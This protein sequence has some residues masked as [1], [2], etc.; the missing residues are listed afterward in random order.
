MTDFYPQRYR[1]VRDRDTSSLYRML[2]IA[3]EHAPA[4]LKAVDWNAPV[5]STFAYR[6]R[7]GSPLRGSLNFSHPLSAVIRTGNLELLKE[8]LAIA[9]EVYK[10]P[11]YLENERN[12]TSPH[13]WV[14]CHVLNTAVSLGEVSQLKVLLEAMAQNKGHGHRYISYTMEPNPWAAMASHGLADRTPAHWVQVLKLLDEQ[15]FASLRGVPLGEDTTVEIKP[16]RKLD[17]TERH[18]RQITHTHALECAAMGGNPAL[19]EAILS[20]K[21]ASITPRALMEA[22]R[23]GG[24]D[25]AVMMLQ[26]ASLETMGLNHRGE[27]TLED[28]GHQLT[29]AWHQWQ[30]ATV[31][32]HPLAGFT[33]ADI[34]LQKEAMLH[35]LVLWLEKLV[36]LRTRKAQQKKE[37]L[38][39]QAIESLAPTLAPVL[40]ALPTEQAETAWVH[41]QA[42]G[43]PL[44]TWKE[45]VE[46]G[47]P[48]YANSAWVRLQRERV[49]ALDE[50]SANAYV[51]QMG[52]QAQTWWT[53]VEQLNELYPLYQALFEDAVGTTLSSKAWLGQASDQL[54]EKLSD[55]QGA[56]LKAALMEHSWDS[57]PS[58]P[59]LRL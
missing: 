40:G 25:L 8:A 37:W 21:Q 31:N 56:E 48:D 28:V 47:K 17:A 50:E 6:E 44:P 14:G 41:A 52:Q 24:A 16:S 20:L 46:W 2:E 35:S 5:V 45:R 30:Q 33:E 26:R 38:S 22:W 10:N 3:A 42:L 51:S 54:L 57:A 49:S 9:T 59:K 19:T 39:P 58:A 29:R 4:L 7:E 27:P 15:T 18:I 36:D 32:K 55:I 13:D 43:W 12:Y 11:V 23:E 34:A 1:P 53:Q